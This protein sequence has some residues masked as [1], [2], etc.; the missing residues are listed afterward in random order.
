[1][2][3]RWQRN[4]VGRPLSPPQ[5][6]QKSISM[7]SKFHK[8]TSECR[9]RTSGTQKSS[10]LSS[11]TVIIRLRRGASCT[12]RKLSRRDGRGGKLQRLRSPDTWATRT[13]ERHKTQ[14]QPGLHLWGLPECLSLS[15][16]DLGGARSPGP[17]SEG[18]QQS[19]LEP[20]LCV[21]W[22]RAGPAWLRHCEHMP[23]LFVC[24]IPPS[25]QHDWTSEPK[26]CVHHR[27]PCVR[28]EIRHWRDQQTEK[29]KQ[30]E[31]PWKWQVK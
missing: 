19:N 4:R 29:L 16:L 1:M 5:I 20:E 2:V 10:S 15:R 17:A 11:K 7:L 13:W 27:P 14:A 28:A 25:P 12:P 8:T 24:S 23:V 6:H 21:L 31:P 18:S 30:R 22:V 26:K 9:Q 3:L